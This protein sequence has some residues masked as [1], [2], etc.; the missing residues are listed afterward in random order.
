MPS[1]PVT[2]LTNRQLADNLEHFTNVDPGI[3]D[4]LI[5]EARRRLYAQPD[6]TVVPPR[7]PAESPPFKEA[8]CSHCGRTMVWRQHGGWVHQDTLVLS[9]LTPGSATSRRAATKGSP[10]MPKKEQP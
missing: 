5:T 8:P 2:Q 1:I 10:A 9:C 7:A 6:V 4:T 3:R